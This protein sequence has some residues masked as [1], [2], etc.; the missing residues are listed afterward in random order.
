MDELRSI[1][2]MVILPQSHLHKDERISL[3]QWMNCGQFTPWSFYPSHFASTKVSSL[4]NRSH[5]APFKSYFAPCKTLVMNFLFWC[6]S[7][8][9]FELMSVQIYQL[10]QWNISFD[11][12]PQHWFLYIVIPQTPRYCTEG[13]LE[14]VSFF[15]LIVLLM[16]FQYTF[17]RVTGW[18]LAMTTHHWNGKREL[19][20]GDEGR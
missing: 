1:H 15:I 2:P 9:D 7:W 11:Y 8:T 13:I 17:M 4:H 3:C 19:Y 12:F 14:G 6:W 16:T 10:I 18:K 20:L 5:F